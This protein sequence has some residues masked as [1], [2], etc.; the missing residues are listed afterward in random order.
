[1]FK[2]KLKFLPLYGRKE[3]WFYHTLYLFNL[4]LLIMKEQINLIDVL[5]M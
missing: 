1:M 2:K 4:F 5:V 3:L